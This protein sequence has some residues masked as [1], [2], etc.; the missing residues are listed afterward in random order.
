[1]RALYRSCSV[2]VQDGAIKDSLQCSITL[3]LEQ[4]HK[5]C[6]S[7]QS[8]NCSFVIVHI[9]LYPFVNFLSF[10]LCRQSFYCYHTAGQRTAKQVGTSFL[11]A[12]F[13]MSCNDMSSRICISYGKSSN[14]RHEGVKCM[15][16]TDFC[17]LESP[18]SVRIGCNWKFHMKGNPLLL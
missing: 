3:V 12:E 9:Y 2:E 7:G 17:L 14:R 4:I 10:S 11:Q 13:G 6:F 18:Q 15:G 5:G 1:M 8:S 16:Q